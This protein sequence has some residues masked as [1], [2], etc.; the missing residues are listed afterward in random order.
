MDTWGGNYHAK[1]YMVEDVA[2]TKGD[3]LGFGEVV[4]LICLILR[5]K[6]SF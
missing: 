5:A 1:P 4:N 6:I 3:S 2:L